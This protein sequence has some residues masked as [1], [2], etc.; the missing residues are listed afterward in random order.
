[1]AKH[2]PTLGKIACQ[3]GKAF[4]SR[5]WQTFGG[6]TFEKAIFLQR[7]NHHRAEWQD[8]TANKSLRIVMQK[9]N[10]FIKLTGWWQGKDDGN[11]GGGKSRCGKMPRTKYPADRENRET[12]SERKWFCYQRD[13]LCRRD[14]KMWKHVIFGAMAVFFSQVEVLPMESAYSSNNC[15]L[16]GWS[17]FSLLCTNMQAAGVAT[18]FVNM[19]RVTWHD[20]SNILRQIAH[21]L[22]LWKKVGAEIKFTE[23]LD[24]TSLIEI[25]TIPAALIPGK[26]QHC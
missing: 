26:K 23:S 22:K 7:R 11:D 1:M 20:L 4:C 17:L 6:N 10:E 16:R 21:L 9:Q 5:A 3:I 2:L 15:I 18:R 25:L 24:M 14:S 8:E 12:M 19:R 13:A